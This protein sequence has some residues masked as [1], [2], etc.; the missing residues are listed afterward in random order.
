MSGSVSLQT[1]VGNLG[2]AGLS[3]MRTVLSALST[4]DVQPAAM[5]QIQ[6]IGSL[7]HVNGKFA[8]TISDELQRSP[9]HRLDMLSCAIGW[10]KGDATS[11]L[12]QSAGGQAAALLALFLRNTYDHRTAGEILYRFSQRYMPRSRCVA[13]IKQLAEVLTKVSGKIASMGYGNF[14]AEQVTKLRLVYLQL[15]RAI[16]ACFLCIMTEETTAEILECISRAQRETG[17]RARIR[18]TTSVSHIMTLLLVLCAEDVE[19]SVEGTVIHGGSNKRI[20]LEVVHPRSD[21]SGI[22]RFQLETAIEVKEFGIGT[23]I[24]GENA[25]LP[26]KDDMRTFSWKG[27]L[28][29]R[30]D[31]LLYD[32]HL[33]HRDDLIADC[34]NS[35]GIYSARRK[36]GRLLVGRAHGLSR[37]DPS[38]VKGYKKHST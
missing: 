33:L 37:W 5:L 36:L 12:S 3:S 4:D 30:L 34:C 15:N 13:S 18:G 20:F 1:D 8:S 32:Y 21:H 22:I 7:F 23:I 2:L 27:W 16:P 24:S 11:M 9:S 38:P 6:D 35:S 26:M 17:T 28:A 19:V 10:R 29:A 14:L 25:L 31:I